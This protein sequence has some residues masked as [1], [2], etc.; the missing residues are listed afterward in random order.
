MG[1]MGGAGQ[2]LSEIHRPE[3]VEGSLLASPAR[4][5]VPIRGALRLTTLLGTPVPHLGC[6]QPPLEWSLLVRIVRPGIW[7][8]WQESAVPGSTVAVKQP[9][10]DIGNVRSFG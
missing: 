9:P 4:N 7:G 8:L 10:K 3:A 1:L 5:A 6:P 2:D